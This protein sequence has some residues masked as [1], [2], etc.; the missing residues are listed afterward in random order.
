LKKKKKEK[1]GAHCPQFLMI[2][3]K[4]KKEKDGGSAQQL[5]NFVKRWKQSRKL[6]VLFLRGM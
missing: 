3:K 1:N 4:R 2:K 6:S 5:F